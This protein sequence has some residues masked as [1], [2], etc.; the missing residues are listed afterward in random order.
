MFAPAGSGGRCKEVRVEVE[1]VS[2]GGATPAAD[3][4]CTCCTAR[5][6]VRCRPSRTDTATP[7]VHAMRNGLLTISSPRGMERTTRSTSMGS[8]GG[9]ATRGA[10]VVMGL[11]GRGGGTDMGRL[12]KGEAER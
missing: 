4:G 2:R 11:C 9:G 1:V 6:N 12:R 7:S 8:A 3:G 10:V 5:L